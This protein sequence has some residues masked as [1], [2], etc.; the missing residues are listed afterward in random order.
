MLKEIEDQIERE[1]EKR[2]GKAK[3]R[4]A[5]YKKY[6]LLCKKRTGEDW[7]EWKD[8]GQISSDKQ[9][10]PLYCRNNAKFLARGIYESLRKK[11]YRPRQ[12]VRLVKEKP[13]GGRRYIDIFSIPDAAVSKVIFKRLRKR[14]EKVFSDSSFAYSSDKSQLDAVFR[15]KSILD[16]DK[17]FVAKYDFSNYFSSIKHDILAAVLEEEKFFITELEKAFILSLVKYEYRC[18]EDDEVLKNE[19]GIPQG[20]SISSFLANMFADS[21]DSDLRKLRGEFVRYADDSIVVND[22]YRDSIKCYCAYKK[23]SRDKSIEINYRKFSGIR[24][25]AS[26]PH[27]AKV[28]EMEGVEKIDFLGYSIKNGILDISAA[29]VNRMKCKCFKIIYNNM[30]FFPKKKG[31]VCQNRTGN[32]FVDWELITCVNEL[33]RS[34]YGGYSEKEIRDFV[35][36]KRNINKFYNS[37]SYFCLSEREE[38]VKAL[39]GWLVSTICKLYDERVKLLESY[40]IHQQTIDRQHL[41]SG[42]WYDHEKIS[43]ETKKQDARL[44]SFYLAWKAAQRSWK[45]RGMYGVRSSYGYD[46]NATEDGMR[47]LESISGTKK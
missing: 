15:L 19:Q 2:S 5:R 4:V 12:V 18:S 6:Q 24:L 32:G 3:K 26:N 29:A 31:K 1:A 11:A 35:R 17:V 47:M 34:I 28:M 41:I 27:E 14:N 23:F 46:Y 37:I 38:T 45:L 33:R 44:P 25:Y 22:S 16:L 36:G 30:I 20:N 42:K 43:F 9:F 39:D 10:D 13:D 21:L 40:G 7:D 8:R